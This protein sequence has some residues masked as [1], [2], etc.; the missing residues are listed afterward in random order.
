MIGYTL[1]PFVCL[2]L[3][4][5]KRRYASI[6]FIAA[7]IF[8]PMGV[9]LEWGTF[10]IYPIRLFVIV[11][12]I[13][14]I[15]RSEM[16]KITSVDAPALIF[17][18][19][20]L[21]SGLFHPPVTSAIIWRAGMISNTIG[22]YIVIR[23]WI[24]DT[25][26]LELFLKASLICLFPLAIS[27]AVEHI[28]GKNYFN[29]IGGVRLTPAIRE[30]QYRAQGPFRH[31]ILAGTV[32]AACFP[33]AI[34]FWNK[35][36]KFSFCSSVAALVIPML[37]VSSGPIMTFAV[38]AF[39]TV[40]WKWRHHMR[41]IVRGGLIMLVALHIL[42]K[43]PVWYLIAKIDFTGGST[44]W[45]RARLIDSAVTYLSEWWLAGTDYTRHWMPT[46]VTWN[47]DHTDITNHFLKM[48]VIR[49]ATASVCIYFHFM[50]G[51]SSN[52]KSIEKCT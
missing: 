8:I 35:K 49:R 2:L 39:A 34:A 33:M 25:N 28:T 19:L 18:P 26:D 37:T 27:M 15:L 23:C 24:K 51:V 6:V 32:G 4:A 44:S 29:Y 21:I 50:D 48:G 14:I 30:G 12:I 46:G 36:R 42:M 9:S 20:C 1:I 38:A 31:A 43:A 17:I 41:R 11:G 10:H 7:I 45:H 3:L 5:V 52:I 16:F 13:R 22:V 47:A 40:L